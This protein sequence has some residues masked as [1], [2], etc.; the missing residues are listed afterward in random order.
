MNSKRS[1]GQ[2][3]EGLINS[4]SN[5]ASIQFASPE[6]SKHV[7]ST[8]S[9]VFFLFI[10]RAGS[11]VKLF[12]LIWIIS[13]WLSVRYCVVYRPEP[14]V[15]MEIDIAWHFV[16]AVSFSPWVVIR[17]SHLAGSKHRLSGVCVN[18]GEGQHLFLC[19]LFCLPKV[20]CLSGSDEHQLIG[21]TSPIKNSCHWIYYSSRNICCWRHGTVPSLLPS[22]LTRLPQLVPRIDIAPHRA[23]KN[24]SVDAERPAS[25][26]QMLVNLLSNAVKFTP[27]GG[28]IRIQGSLAAPPEVLS[29][30]PEYDDDDEDDHDDG[31]DA[32][33]D[34]TN[35]N[36]TN[37]VQNRFRRRR[38]NNDSHRG[39]NIR[40]FT[41]TANGLNLQHNNFNNGLVV[42]LDGSNGLLA[43]LARR[44]NGL[45]L[46]RSNRGD[47]TGSTNT[48][49]PAGG[50]TTPNAHGSGN[51]L[52]GND[53][54]PLPLMVLSVTDSGPG[55]PEADIARCVLMLC[56]C[57][58]SLGL[59][60]LAAV[61]H[62]VVL[63][64]YAFAGVLVASVG[65]CWGLVM[66]HIAA[67]PNL[68][69][70]FLPR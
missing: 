27:P 34:N 33:T 44:R 23:R 62:I 59:R 30:V 16:E 26:S 1:C 32:V 51:S 8:A 48:P 18:Y 56:A 53:G 3:C 37:S 19:L 15:L 31:I 61:E 69:R 54:K 25:S 4:I 12:L 52:P 11:C 29:T 24:I 66:R 21:L 45:P 17:T 35:T 57:L 41:N 38:S 63:Y 67:Y 40:N 65:N 39:S 50:L 46:N 6:D 43:R 13:T 49:P 22:S 68:R 5:G 55:I 2:F 36:A 7:C 20:S 10:P 47:K 28:V 64:S 60:M 42:D 58:F 14:T 9:R 70:Q